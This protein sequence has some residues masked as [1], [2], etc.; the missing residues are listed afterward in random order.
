[1]NKRFGLFK[2]TSATFITLLVCPSI[3]L[4]ATNVSLKQTPDGNAIY[5]NGRATGIESPLLTLKWNFVQNGSEVFIYESSSGGTAC[6]ATYQIL[7]TNE[8]AIKDK[9]EVGNCSDQPKVSQSQSEFTL[10]FPKF[11]SAPGSIV[12]IK[13]GTIS[14]TE[15]ARSVTTNDSQ[16]TNLSNSSM[17][18]NNGGNLLEKASILG[19]STQEHFRKF[20]DEGGL[21]ANSI[22]HDLKVKE[23]D[24]RYDTNGKLNLISLKIYPE[25]TEYNFIGIPTRK[26]AS[27]KRVREILGTL[28][29]IQ[30]SN[31]RIY[32][33]GFEG[34]NSQGW[35]CVYQAIDNIVIVTSKPF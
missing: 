35:S 29:N 30:P 25:H 6:A 16:R 18:K 14:D 15:D 31:W 12:R 2:P 22:W 5:L 10:S 20:K 3:V 27:P 26:L 32:D 21:A 33:S 11:G 1:M 24:A 9:R 34:K 23:V 13:N 19:F 7:I 17:T 28:C 8:N 4:G